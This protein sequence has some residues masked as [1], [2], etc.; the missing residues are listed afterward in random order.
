[1]AKEKYDYRG[2]PMEQH[3]TSTNGNTTDCNDGVNIVVE[4][5]ENMAVYSSPKK[6]SD[7]YVNIGP[8]RR[9]VTPPE[10]VYEEAPAV[11]SKDIIGENYMDTVLRPKDSGD[12][13]IV[14]VYDTHPEDV[15]SDYSSVKSAAVVR[16]KTTDY[17]DV[18]VDIIDTVNDVSEIVL[19]ENEVSG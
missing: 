6:Q 12:S 4:N 9:D 18:D 1:M 15:V 16:N 5:S 14:A 10:T 7:L 11:P 8:G 3:R 2:E 17:E 19:E 13:G